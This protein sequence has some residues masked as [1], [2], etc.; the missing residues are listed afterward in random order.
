MLSSI[1]LLDAFRI[2]VLSADTF[3]KEKN[4]QDLLERQFAMS[5]P[6]FK[7]KNVQNRDLKVM[8]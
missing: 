4:K 2:K 3:E 6:T 8:S 7:T 5:V 1:I